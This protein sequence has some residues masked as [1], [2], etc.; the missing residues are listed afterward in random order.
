MAQFDA[1][2][3]EIIPLYR[4]DS[5]RSDLESVVLSKRIPVPPG[6]FKNAG[7]CRLPLVS[8]A[9]VG[10]KV[11][12]VSSLSSNHLGR[13]YGDVEMNLIFLKGYLLMV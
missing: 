4:Y 6:Y 9:E 10:D 2:G 3:N 12:D 7:R 13:Q 1:I 8:F 11:S 5:S